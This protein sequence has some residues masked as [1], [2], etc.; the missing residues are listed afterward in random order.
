M[1]DL[2]RSI[3]HVAA[4]IGL[5][6]V[7][8]CSDAQSTAPATV[9]TPL[10]RLLRVNADYNVIHRVDR[11]VAATDT[12][13]TMSGRIIAADVGASYTVDADSPF[14]SAYLTIAVSSSDQSGLDTVV[15]EV[16]KP[17]AV[18]VKELSSATFGEDEVV[19]LA[20]SEPLFSTKNVVDLDDTPNP[21]NLY[22]V[23]SS[24]MGALAMRDGSII[25]LTTGDAVLNDSTAKSESQLVE[26][27]TRAL[28]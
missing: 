15:I 12:D 5:L 9:P 17:T 23:S 4:C 21:K 2:I 19:F 24:L 7:G 28:S 3:P 13:H 11:L 26:E 14:E 8:A 22:S 16:Y 6:L 18:G 1:T 27:I 25:S 10:W 20:R